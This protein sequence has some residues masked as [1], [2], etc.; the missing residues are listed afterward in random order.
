[1]LQTARAKI[2]STAVRVMDRAVGF[3]PFI[4]EM[5]VAGAPIRFF[6]ATRQAASWYDPL[7]PR[8]RR[9]LEWLVENL[10]LDGERI[11]DAGAFHGLYAAVFAKAAGPSGHV[12][13]VDPVASNCAVIEANL[14]INRLDG[15]VV[16]CAI[17]NRPGEVRFSRDTCGR[18]LTSGGVAVGA[19]RLRDI[20]PRATVVKLDIEGEEFTVIPE[21]IDEM[22]GVR[23]WIVEIHPAEGRDAGTIIDAFGSRGFRLR[24][25]RPGDGEIVPYAGEAWAERAT[26]VA[27]RDA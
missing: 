21:Q 11:V 9:E 4:R 16:T 5:P 6:V 10:A 14:A 7:K 24:W 12:T 20:A 1:M 19:A 8:N 23:A 18:V 13:A 22:P 3:Q 25:S 2:T 26:L 27:T 17:S 15:E